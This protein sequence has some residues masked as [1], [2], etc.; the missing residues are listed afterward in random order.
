EIDAVLRDAVDESLYAGAL[1]R[2]GLLN[3]RRPAALG[4]ELEHRPQ[5]GDEPVRAGDVGLVDHQNV[6]NLEDARLDSLDVVAQIWHTHDQRRIGRAG[7]LHLI[8]A[9]ADGFDDDHILAKGVQQQHH[10][11]GAASEPAHDTA[12]GHAAYEYPRIAVQ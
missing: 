9:H 4:A 2:D 11:E 5:V 3:W 6:G 1:G 10:V 8:L 7:N 12:R